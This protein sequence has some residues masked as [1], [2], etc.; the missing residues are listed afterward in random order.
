MMVQRGFTPEGTNGTP[1]SGSYRSK[2]CEGQESLANRDNYVLIE[3]GITAAAP[4]TVVN[5]THLQP[6]VIVALLNKTL[7]Y[8]HSCLGEFGI[9]NGIISEIVRQR[10]G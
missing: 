4:G 2:Q 8:P 6:A 9:K 3:L 5:G 10:D 7:G 1:S